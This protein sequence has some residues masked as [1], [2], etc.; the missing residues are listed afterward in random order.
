MTKTE[1]ENY[2]S[3]IFGDVDDCIRCIDCEIG[4]WNGH[5]E[6]CSAR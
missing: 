4:A 6:Y 1:T 5:K 2:N 3:H